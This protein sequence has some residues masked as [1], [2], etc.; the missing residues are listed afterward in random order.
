MSRQ[1]T[2]RACHAS[3]DSGQKCWRPAG[4]QCSIKPPVSLSFERP[5]CSERAQQLRQRRTRLGAHAED[6]DQRDEADVEDDL[7]KATKRQKE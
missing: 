7:A 6:D 3:R 5:A 4:L 1:H 2:T